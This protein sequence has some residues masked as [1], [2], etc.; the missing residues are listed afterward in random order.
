MY[1]EFRFPPLVDLGAVYTRL[2]GKIASVLGL[3]VQYDSFVF[4]VWSVRIDQLL[5]PDTRLRRPTIREYPKSRSNC[6][7]KVPTLRK[8]I[9]AWQ[10]QETRSIAQ[11]LKDK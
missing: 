7:C 10:R 8:M 5:L 1:N 11:H 4:L 3:C 9:L 6:S 2:I